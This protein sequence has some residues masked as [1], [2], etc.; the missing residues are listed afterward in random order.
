[1]KNR[2]L[3]YRQIH[4]DFHTS[5][6]IENI[7]KEFDKNQFINALRAGHVN[8]ITCFSSC[9]HGWSYH[10][11]KV[12]KMH[13]H[14]D[15]DLLGA[16]IKACKENGINVPIYLTAGVDN[17]AAEEHSEWRE[18]DKEGRWASW[19]PSPLQAGFKNLCF[20]TPYLDYLC[21]KIEEAVTRYGKADGVF[22]DIISQSQ[23]CCPSCLE[24]MK[25]QGL[26]PLV[27][28]DRIKCSEIAL[29]RYYERTTAACRI[30]NPDMPV[31]H[32]S[33]HIFPG[34]R[35]I[36]PYFSHLEL[37][38]LP[39]GG[40][41]YDHFPFSARYAA[42]LGMDFLGMTGKF[43][44]TW[45]EFGGFKH[46][47]ALRY[48]CSAMMAFGAKCSIGDQLHPSGLMDEST[49]RIIGQA[50]GEV[51][52]KEPWCSGSRNAADIALLNRAANRERLSGMQDPRNRDY[53]G[54]TGAS[55]ILLEG[56]FLFDVID[57]ET[58]F[59]PYKLL[60]LPDEIVVDSRLKRKLDSHLQSGGKLFITGDSGFDGEGD[61]LF[62]IGGELGE[63]SPYCPDYIKPEKSLSSDFLSSPMVMYSPGRRLKV[64]EGRSLGKVYDPYFNRRYDHFCSHRHTPHRLEDSGFDCGVL[65]GGILYLPH[66]VFTQYYAYGAVV[67]KDFLIKCIKSLLADELSVETDLPSSARLTVRKQDKENRMIVHLLYGNTVTRGGY[68]GPETKPV[69]II[70]GLLPLHHVT[71]KIRTARPRRVLLEPEH[72]EQPWIWRD[73][74]LE[75]RIDSFTCHRM[76]AIEY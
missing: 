62:D 56:H 61:F 66:K 71:V 21:A 6:A 58:D 67:Y 55:R 45:G 53:P 63:P 64:S 76:V 39:T 1:M 54:D 29:K 41:G 13:P 38:S 49:Y 73:G 35:D 47:D 5:P 28:E 57:E 37:E 52:E 10:P 12:G 42:A 14:L 51:E 43:H 34:R 59:N 11:T 23:C 8:S 40:W 26:D 24:L 68:Y 4:L 3:P 18:I 19:E 31:F 16:Q 48:E 15:F 33:G 36:L 65:K 70:D 25:K 22:L 2:D 75:L 20:N 7:G 50:Y 44:T 17:V 74:L 9:H 27:E 46:P 32:N 69:E 72:K 30:N 60:I